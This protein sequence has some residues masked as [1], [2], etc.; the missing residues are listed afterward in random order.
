MTIF[1]FTIMF[2]SVSFAQDSTITLRN[3]PWLLVVLAAIL[4][5]LSLI[6]LAYMFSKAFGIKELSSWATNEFYQIV[7]MSFIVFLIFVILRVE[8]IVFEAYGFQSSMRGENP[9]IDNAKLYLNSVRSYL[10]YV[11]SGILIEKTVLSLSSS[12]ISSSLDI[13]T[14]GIL[15][16]IEKTLFAGIKIFKIENKEVAKSF[17]SVFSSIVQKALGPFTLVYAFNSMQLYFL[18]FIER[19]AF[20]FFLPFGLFFR[21]FSF[22]RKFGNILIALS[23]GFYIVFPLTYLISQNIVDSV[24]NFNTQGSPHSWRDIISARLSANNIDPDLLTN[25]G[26]MSKLKEGFTN[27]V[28]NPISYLIEFMF[29]LVF[30]LFNEAAFAFVLFTLVPIIGFTITISVVRELG[31]LLGSDVS[32]NDVIKML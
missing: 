22:S 13:A 11:M 29:K 8:N 18:D 27:E 15:L 24:L 23:I 5:T 21:V 9:A 26:F 10:V 4:F 25:E 2:A 6:G 3:I 31:S 16:P 12:F 30:A 1:L 14:K 17:I 19:Y 7:M 28:L 32:L 20:H